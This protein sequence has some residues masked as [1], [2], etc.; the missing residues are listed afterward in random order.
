[1][2]QVLRCVLYKR[3]QFNL[4]NLIM[5]LLIRLFHPYSTKETEAQELVTWMVSSK[6]K[7]HLTL[8]VTEA[9][10][11]TPGSSGLQLG[12]QLPPPSP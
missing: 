11:F 2:Y 7:L 6:P 3:C 1:M 9:Q 8:I 5:W 4:H 10:L 12:L